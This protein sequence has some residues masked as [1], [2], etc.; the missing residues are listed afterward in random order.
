[1]KRAVDEIKM[2]GE[3]I[4]GKVRKGGVTRAE[5]SRNEER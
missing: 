3:K 5:K 4:G 2:T 1:M